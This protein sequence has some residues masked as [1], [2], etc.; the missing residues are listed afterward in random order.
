[1]SE[2]LDERVL[3]LRASGVAVEDIARQLAIS[4]ARVER[5]LRRASKRAS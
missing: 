2:K 1:M 5:I 3:R 4:T